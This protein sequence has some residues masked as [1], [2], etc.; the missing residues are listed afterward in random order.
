MERFFRVNGSNISASER[1][2]RQTNRRLLS[3]EIRLSRR[4]SDVSSRQRPCLS[5]ALSTHRFSRPDFVANTQGGKWPEVACR[6]NRT[7][8]RE[9]VKSISSCPEGFARRYCRG[10]R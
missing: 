9:N 6:G 1:S 4:T 8:V 7:T 2:A 10:T 3:E 5:A